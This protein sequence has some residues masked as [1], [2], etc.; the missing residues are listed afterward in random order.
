MNSTT[1][2][3]RF[4]AE[5]SEV[6]G[7]MIHSLYRHPEVF[8]RELVSNA[9]DALDKRRFEA[10]TSPELAASEGEA[11]IRIELD[12]AQRTL[13][14][15]DGGVGMSREEL[16]SN[17]GTIARSG[18]KAF[19]AELRKAESSTA[20]ELIGQFGVGFYSSFLVAERV[21][22]VS[23][24]AGSDESWRWSSDGRGEFT[25][26][27]AERA[28]A[29]TSVVLHLKPDEPQSE[30]SGEHVDWLDEGSVRNVVKR[31]SDFVAWPIELGGKVQ[32]AQK[33][34]W[35]RSKDEIKPEEY[36][37]FYKLIAHDWKDPALTVHFKAEGTSEYTALLFVP[38]EKPFD[39]FERGE[40][41]SRIA[42]YVKRVLI[43]QDCEDLLPPW[44][45]FVRGLVDASDLPLNV[46]RDVLQSTPLVR[47][48]K[49]RLT[50]RVVDEL[51][52]LLAEKRAEFETLFAHFGSVLKEGIYAGED[53]DKKLAK[54]LLFDST[55]EE[56]RTTLAEYVARM[57]K[58]QKAIYY[59]AG[60]EKSVLESSPHL[61]SYKKREL[62][63]L[64]MSDPVDEWLLSRLS[65]FDGKPL[66]AVDRG[67]HEIASDS[68][69]QA[70]EDLARGQRALLTSIEEQLT[71]DVSEARFSTRL[72]DS[73]ALLVGDPGGI[74]PQMA[75]VLKAANQP[76]PEQKRALELNPDHALVKRL[77]D[78]YAKDPKAAGVG[79]L[80]ELLHGQ[81]LLAEGSPLADPAKFAKLLSRMVVGTSQ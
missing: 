66:Q 50:R 35:T 31:Y 62:E 67:A 47:Q 73:P 63:V 56:G 26:E 71:Q 49:K 78:A 57:H 32:N 80:V 81:A 22:V 34:L 21:E 54:L 37:E 14:V 4:Q 58:E 39:M 41:R 55:R 48:I 15:L 77:M 79:D 68:E 25:L 46:S 28:E 18:T 13:S 16:V 40:P 76:V 61:E 29:G 12:A 51:A 23:R 72:C 5:A 38:S 75:R 64:L 7:L 10:L 52:R 60:N 30:D 19:L 9:S 43:V 8:L 53:E 3:L 74:S 45:R 42:L 44:L 6:L 36:A 2:T 27:P 24:R 1:E 20:P 69:K 11:R 65:E 17:L 33:P 70:A 59:L